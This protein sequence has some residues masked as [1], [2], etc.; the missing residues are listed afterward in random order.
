MYNTNYSVPI[1]SIKIQNNS[2]TQSLANYVI[3]GN[4]IDRGITS[5]IML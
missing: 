5:I 4:I 1:A 2:I 3:S